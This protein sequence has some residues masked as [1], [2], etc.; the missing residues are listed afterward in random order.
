MPDF[1]KPTLHYS[2]K[3]NAIVFE[4]K[5]FGLS[6]HCWE[7]LFES[8]L[9]SWWLV[10]KFIWFSYLL[11]K[12]LLPP[13]IFHEVHSK[14]IEIMNLYRDY[15][16]EQPF[17]LEVNSNHLCNL[18]QIYNPMKSKKTCH[19][20]EHPLVLVQLLNIL[21]LKMQLF[22]CNVLLFSDANLVCWKVISSYLF[23]LYLLSDKGLV[24]IKGWFSIS[25]AQI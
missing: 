16:L 23:N 25:A 7:M 8:L 3:F 10:P 14:V 1:G 4:W 6:M 20:I 19:H 22:L 13:G 11:V 5:V 2:P 9:V 15:C 18:F 17:W 12:T 21:L 24:Q